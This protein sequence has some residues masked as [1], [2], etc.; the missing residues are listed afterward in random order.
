MSNNAVRFSN[1]K[2]K[3]VVGE[4]SHQPKPKFEA[5]RQERSLQKLTPKT[6]NQKIYQHMLENMTLIVAEGFA[7]CVDKETEFLSPRG[8]VKMSDY[9]DGDLVMQV[10]ERGLCA[11]FVKPLAYIKLPC[12]DFYTIEKDR[13]INQWLSEE[14]NVAYTVKNKLKLN[15]KNILEVIN[16]NSKTANGF[17]GLI[18]TVYNF[19]GVSLGLSVDEIRLGVAIKADAHLATVSTGRY[20]FKLKRSR[21]VERLLEI[22]NS[23]DKP[24]KAKY[25]AATE[26][27]TITLYA[28]EHTKSLKDWMFCSKEDAEVIMSEYMYWDGDFSP[29]GKRQS[30]FSTS[31]K[32]EADAM[33]HF[34]NMCGYRSTISI[35]NRIGRVQITGGKEYVRKTNE[36]NVGFSKQ[37]HIK[38][39]SKNRD[40]SKITEIV[41]KPSV[42]GL[43]Y[44]FTVPSGFLVL[45]REDCVFVTGNCGKTMMPCY[46]AA[47]LMLAKKIEKIV[48]VRPYTPLANKTIGF[49]P[50]DENSKL[51]PYVLPMLGYLREALGSATVDI[52]LADKRIEIQAL[53]SIRGRSFENAYIVADELQTALLPEVQ[54]LTTRIG[55]NC[56]LVATGDSRQNDIKSGEDGITYLKRILQTYD[57]RDSGVV[58]FT[59]D[60][61]VRSGITKD[62]LIAYSE[63]GWK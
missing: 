5:E 48:L 58:E 26:Y 25:D 29:K 34:G 19:N 42:D 24:Y 6:K 60:D 55:N 21:K 44:C 14:H 49:L 30:R 38:L 7:G 4:S 10:S 61:C 63:D 15:K 16:D 40:N 1:R 31:I 8:W 9:K 52:M 56:K 59:I 11:E 57:I 45:R 51:M 46:H 35:C 36:Y 20:V 39:I 43:K 37:T 53:E 13:G 33:Q 54:A 18:P 28:P 12:T 3:K 2:S 32:E 41:K 50:G 22:L 27:H 17:I 47:S 23:L 62:F